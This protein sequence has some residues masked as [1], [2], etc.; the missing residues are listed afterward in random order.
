[1][2]LAE[3]AFRANEEAS[4]FLFRKASTFLSIASFGAPSLS[5]GILATED[6][7]TIGGSTVGTI[8]DCDVL[9]GREDSLL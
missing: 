1:M 9:S 6:N 4:M 3:A 5:E 8:R 2:E 7:A